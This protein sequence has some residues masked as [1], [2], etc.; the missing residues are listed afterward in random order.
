MKPM[1]PSWLFG[2]IHRRWGS[3]AQHH[4][5]YPASYPAGLEGTLTVAGG[6][7]LEVRPIRPD[8][9]EALRG[10]FARLSPE[11]VYRRF[12]GHL[13]EL[14]LEAC[15]YL[16]H[17][18][19]EDHLA[20]VA[21]E[22]GTLS[23]VAVARYYRPEGS[24]LAEAAVV[25]TDEWQGRG[26]GPALFERLIAAARDRDIEGFEAF[27]QEDNTRLLRSLRESGY[28]LVQRREGEVVRVELRFAGMPVHPA[29]GSGDAAT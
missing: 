8:D 7:R 26:V 17:V 12:H 22:P 1:N 27:V 29:R 14:S 10:G 3:V 21:I 5:G 24:R 6:E 4:A 15:R 28:G 11:T 16:T 2:E 19:Y 20:L 23:G 9:V 13:S 18:D 25:V